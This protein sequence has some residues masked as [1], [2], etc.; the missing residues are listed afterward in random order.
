MSLKKMLCVAV[1]LTTSSIQQTQADWLSSLAAKM[2]SEEKVLEKP[3]QW[4]RD[5]GVDFGCGAIDVVVALGALAASPLYIPAKIVTQ[6][7]KCET[8]CTGSFGKAYGNTF[9][10]KLPTF[11]GNMDEIKDDDDFKK[12]LMCMNC[13]AKST[14]KHK[15]NVLNT[16]TKAKFVVSFYNL[17]ARISSNRAGLVGD[18]GYDEVSVLSKF[19]AFGNYKKDELIQFCKTK[20]EGAEVNLSKNIGTLFA[21]VGASYYEEGTPPYVE[22]KKELENRLREEGDYIEPAA[23]ASG[24]G[25]PDK[26]DGGTEAASPAR[27]AAEGGSP[28]D[29]AAHGS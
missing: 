23:A 21:V 14:V 18:I 26:S 16:L 19:L 20:L 27:D 7:V 24:T 8:K 22:S 29:S 4:C 25:S 12:M 5:Q 6:K 28:S 1:L 3:G 11:K 2:S 9:F 17:L 13:S 10:E 15:C